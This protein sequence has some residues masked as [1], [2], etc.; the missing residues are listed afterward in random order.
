MTHPKYERQKI[1]LPSNDGKIVQG[2]E[3]QV[4]VTDKEG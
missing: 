4:L 1:R 3:G 2:L